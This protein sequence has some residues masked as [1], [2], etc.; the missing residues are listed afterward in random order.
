VKVWTIGEL[1]GVIR[2]AQP[3]VG[4]RLQ[5]V[6]SLEG[7]LLLG[8][9]AP[10][11]GVLW[12]WIDLNALRP[13]LLPW[14]N[15]PWQLKPKK[16]PLLLFI[17]AHFVGRTLSALK[18]REEAGRIVDFTFES[19]EPLRLEMKLYPHARNVTA[20]CGT[21]QIHW[22]KPSEDV[23]W[24]EQDDSRIE[25][26]DLETLRDQWLKLRGG[27]RVKGSSS[28]KIGAEDEAAKLARE[29]VRR[30]KAIAKIN[31]E[32]IR[33]RQTP[34]REV[35]H[36]LK[37]NQTLKVPREWEPFIDAKRNLA[38]NIE[39]CFEK[40]REVDG[41][42]K[43]AEKRLQILQAELSALKRGEG[44]TK[45]TL[46]N[47]ASSPPQVQDVQARTLKLEDGLTV[48]A[49][50]NAADNMKLLRRARAWD[51]WLHL[52]DFPGSH[53]ILFRNKNATISDGTLHKV[54][55]WFVRLQLKQKY[56]ESAGERLQILVAECRHV[57]PIKGD[58][59]GR[60]T[61]HDE[62]VL[63]HKIPS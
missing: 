8:F 41:K 32:L 5:E 48:M 31:E 29:V 39:R 40:A 34:W 35:G 61:Y 43:G 18:M 17:K 7:D 47:R 30:D 55:E 53:A 45:E 4:L 42:S 44:L 27:V 14:M 16:T 21:K 22:Q 49:G 20:I 9:Y 13:C 23:A 54:A 10:S 2:A 33:Q 25:G 36:W 51:L 26:R 52:R 12:L 57:K 38:W 28:A 56:R 60:V 58:K 59:L 62:R 46:G 11:K 63:I 3:L 50:K 37:S 24:T 6:L 19:E 15:L 1:R